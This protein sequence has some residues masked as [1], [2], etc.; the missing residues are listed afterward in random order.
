M[1]R[2]AGS[3]VVRGESAVLDATYTSGHERDRLI[4]LAQAAGAGIHFIL[5]TCSEDTVKSRLLKRQ[6]KGA[7][8]SD[9]R[10]EIFL[11]QRENFAPVSSAV[12]AALIEINTETSVDQAVKMI[13]QALAKE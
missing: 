6:E 9:G 1:A 5:C 8:V 11:K 7:S 3:R 10:W 12:K 4:E 13:D 2:M